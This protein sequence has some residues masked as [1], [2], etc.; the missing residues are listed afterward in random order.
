M[1]QTLP[2]FFYRQNTLPSI[3]AFLIDF[4]L[5]LRL[6]LAAVAAAV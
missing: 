1:L 3:D 5:N 6:W 4:A 2:L